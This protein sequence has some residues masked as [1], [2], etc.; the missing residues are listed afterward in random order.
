[1]N[2]K[3]LKIIGKISNELP[4]QLFTAAIENRR[5]SGEDVIQANTKEIDGKPVDPKGTYTMRLPVKR[6]IDHKGRMKKIYK[7]RGKVGLITYLRPYV[8]PEK[9]GEVQVFIMK[10]IP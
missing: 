7:K 4:L 9:F 1:M 6:E 8:I 2:K 5:V 3:A 10:N